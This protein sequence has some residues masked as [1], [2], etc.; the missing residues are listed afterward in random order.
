MRMAG[1]NIKGSRQKQALPQAPLWDRM[2]RPKAMKQFFPMERRE[3][4]ALLFLVGFSVFSFLPAWRETE[5]AG[6]A[7]FGWLMAALMVISPLLA[8]FVFV[9]GGRPRG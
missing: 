6:M 3:A 8:L 9:W 4:Y 5:V 2:P 1:V 7:V